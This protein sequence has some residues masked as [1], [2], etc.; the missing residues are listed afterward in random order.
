MVSSSP[1]IKEHQRKWTV[2]KYV[3]CITGR[4]FTVEI[5]AQTP[6]KLD[7][8]NLGFSV[9]VDGNWVASPLLS[10]PEYQDNRYWKAQVI[11]PVTAIAGRSSVIQKMKFAEVQ[12]CKYLC[13]S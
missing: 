13:L 1:V 6:Y 11:G 9:T 2:T 5:T 7:C 4:E 10:R 3:E 12:T 8:A